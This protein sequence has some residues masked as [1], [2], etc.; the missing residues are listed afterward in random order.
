MFQ[1]PTCGMLE[2]SEGQHVIPVSFK[3][4]SCGG[5]HTLAMSEKG[6]VYSCGSDMWGQLGQGKDRGELESHNFANPKQ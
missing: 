2:G 4:V 1:K 3:Q 5:S 6:M